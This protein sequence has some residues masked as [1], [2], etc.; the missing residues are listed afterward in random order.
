MHRPLTILAVLGVALALASLGEG[1]AAPAGGDRFDPYT[2]LR[3]SV[4]RAASGLLAP[5][6]FLAISIE[7]SCPPPAILACRPVVR[8]V[9]G[10]RGEPHQVLELTIGP[11]LR[12]EPSAPAG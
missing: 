7:R 9:G 1:R 3:V 4:P 6:S 12:L 5:F 2:T 8:I 11:G 10:L